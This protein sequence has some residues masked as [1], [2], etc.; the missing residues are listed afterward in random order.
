M[1]VTHVSW[2]WFLKHVFFGSYSNI[3]TMNSGT[4]KNK[5]S[6]D[7]TRRLDQAAALA[8]VALC[9]ELSERNGKLWTKVR[10]SNGNN[11]IGYISTIQELVISCTSCCFPMLHTVDVCIC[12]HTKRRNARRTQTSRDKP[13]VRRLECRAINRSGPSKSCDLDT[14]MEQQ[15]NVTVANDV[16]SYYW[17][18]I[19][20][21][22]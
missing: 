1:L 11:C 8:F 19:W 14:L 6:V 10:T 13:T 5:V 21:R 17:S 18:I 12:W 22:R 15:W 2:P 9:D 3:V 20:W 4:G 16:D 7:L